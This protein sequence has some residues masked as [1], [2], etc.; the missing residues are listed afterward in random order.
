MLLY[1]NKSRLAKCRSCPDKTRDRGPQDFPDGSRR[2]V[3]F[4]NNCFQRRYGSLARS[5]VQLQEFAKVV[6]KWQAPKAT[7]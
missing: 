7:T 4:C 1:L 2:W 5:R 3:P 6:A